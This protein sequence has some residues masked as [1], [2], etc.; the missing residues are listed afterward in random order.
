M[1]YVQSMCP[2]PLLM[3][4]RNRDSPTSPNNTPTPA[5]GE[6][7]I[8]LWPSKEASVSLQGLTYSSGVIKYYEQGSEFLTLHYP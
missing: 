2:S 4:P 3:K 7:E 6:L 8:P 5:H 1:T